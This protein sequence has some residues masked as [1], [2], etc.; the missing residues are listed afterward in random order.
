MNLRGLPVEYCVFSCGSVLFARARQSGIGVARCDRAGARDRE[1]CGV[2]HRL[3]PSRRG[4]GIQRSCL[5]GPG[6][7]LRPARQVLAWRCR[8]FRS[9]AESLRHELTLTWARQARLTAAGDRTGLPGRSGSQIVR[10]R[11]SPA[12]RAVEIP[13][14]ARS[15][16]MSRST[17]MASARS[18]SSSASLSASA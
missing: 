7:R 16:S 5:A 1:R 10:G 11:G 6:Q 18:D 13:H 9:Q 8:R 15:V 14:H 3:G 2:P 4:G 17:C 12:G